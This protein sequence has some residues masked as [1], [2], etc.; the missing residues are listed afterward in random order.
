MTDN[1]TLTP[2]PTLE[3]PIQ[4]TGAIQ[5]LEAREV[6]IA[7]QDEPVT[8]IDMYVS[9]DHPELSSVLGGAA[10]KVGFPARVNADTKLG[11]FLRR[12]GFDIS[13]PVDL[14]AL[15]GRRVSVNCDKEP[16]SDGGMYWRIERDT[17]QPAT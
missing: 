17:I 2:T 6:N 3:G 13:K 5:N 9:V 14:Q 7:G 1:L 11:A 16:G 15:K 10:L 8:Y 12:F 4:T